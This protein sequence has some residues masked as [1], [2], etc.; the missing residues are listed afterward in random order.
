[1][2]IAFYV[3]FSRLWRMFIK[4]YLAIVSLY[5]PPSMQLNPPA[6][7]YRVGTTSLNLTLPAPNHHSLSGIYR[8]WCV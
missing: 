7:P 8:G 2:I 4:L 1:M 6:I 5:K 3:Y